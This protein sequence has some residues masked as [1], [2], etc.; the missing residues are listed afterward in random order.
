MWS[1][2]RARSLLLRLIVLGHIDFYQLYD[3]PHLPASPRAK[4]E[5]VTDTQWLKWLDTWVRLVCV[6]RFTMPPTVSCCTD[7]CGRVKWT[8]RWE[9]ID[10]IY[11]SLADCKTK[12]TIQPLRSCPGKCSDSLM[13]NFV[14]CRLSRTCL[15][16]QR[17]SNF[18]NADSVVN[19][20]IEIEVTSRWSAQ[21]C[22]AHGFDSGLF[23][24]REFDGLV[25]CAKVLSDFEEAGTKGRG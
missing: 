20:M 9:Y 8:R 4:N 18:G 15:P 10:P 2:S 11:S 7:L 19:S 14:S 23:R 13:Y 24:R 12:K 17:W 16:I 3:L 22:L 5:H 1:D 25:E 6:P 21:R